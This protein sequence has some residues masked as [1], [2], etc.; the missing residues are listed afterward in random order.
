MIA[1]CWTLSP[2]H[3]KKTLLLKKKNASY[4]VAKIY[5]RSI[6]YIEFALYGPRPTT[7]FSLYSFWNC[8]WMKSFNHIYKGKKW[9]GPV[10]VSDTLALSSQLLPIALQPNTFQVLFYI[11]KASTCMISGQPYKKV[12]DSFNL[13]KALPPLSGKVGSTEWGGKWMYD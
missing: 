10:M 3:R 6:I 5:A 8:S 13:S 2:Y 7:T 9:S 4:L 12:L 11:K 1:S